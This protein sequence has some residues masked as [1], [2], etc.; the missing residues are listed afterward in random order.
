MENLNA[1]E[2]LEIVKIKKLKKIGEHFYLNLFIKIVYLKC[3]NFETTEIYLYWTKKF[4]CTHK[5]LIH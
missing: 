4:N 1:L 2:K 3:Y 5:N